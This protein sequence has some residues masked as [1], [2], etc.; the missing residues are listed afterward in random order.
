MTLRGTV[1]SAWRSESFPRYRVALPWPECML[2]ASDSV[3]GRRKQPRSHCDSLAVPCDPPILRG[4]DANIE[5][6]TAR[7][8]DTLDHASEEL[9]L[10]ADA[11]ATAEEVAEARALATEILSRYASL[12]SRLDLDDKTEVQRSIGLKVAKIEALLTRFTAG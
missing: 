5:S 1:R 2:K 3:F 6:E 8:A 11:D 4:M 7:L 12:L 9:D 10:A